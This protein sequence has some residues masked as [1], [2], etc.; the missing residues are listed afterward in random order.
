MRARAGSGPYPASMRSALQPDEISVAVITVS[1]RSARGEREDTSGPTAVRALRESGFQAADGWL[2]PDGA[3][4]V[5]SGIEMSIER[6][7]D[8]ILTLGGTGVGPRDQ[9][10]EGTRPV[11]DRELPG[12]CEGLRAEGAS[13]VP[14]AALSRGLAGIS[15][16]SPDGRRSVIVNLPGSPGA[17]MDGVRYLEQLLPHLV[18]QLRGGDH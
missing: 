12:I 17:A 1:D 4:H 3:D 2:V 11:I 6:G 9:T 14:A 7:F 16:P 5:R 13:M 8:V 10:P 18:D 15:R